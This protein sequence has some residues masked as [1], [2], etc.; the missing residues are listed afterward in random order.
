MTTIQIDFWDLVRMGGAAVAALIGAFWVLVVMMVKQFKADLK[1]R[2]DELEKA[3]EEASKNVDKQ[4][5]EL[6]AQHSKAN[7]QATERLDQL[8]T[9]QR[10]T[11]K[12][13]L[14]LRA[15][16]PEKYVRR[17]DAI[18]SEM[19]VHAKLDGLASRMDSLLRNKNNV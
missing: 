16:L 14:M 15:E 6:A 4:L 13:L 17:E 19:T 10:N 18:R 12:E 1:N 3:R 2:F 5:V 9:L 7:T 8:E 11:D